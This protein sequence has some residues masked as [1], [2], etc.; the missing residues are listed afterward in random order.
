MNIFTKSNRSGM[1]GIRCNLTGASTNEI[2]P[3]LGYWWVCCG[4]HLIMDDDRTAIYTFER[5]GGVNGRIEITVK[6]NK[7]VSVKGYNRI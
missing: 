7:V 2:R 4:S 5:D 3:R 1:L 6:H